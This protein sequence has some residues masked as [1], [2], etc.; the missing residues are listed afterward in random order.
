[1]QRAINSNIN[2]NFPLSKTFHIVAETLEEKEAKLLEKVK[3]D[4]ISFLQSYQ[5]Y[6]KW[7]WKKIKRSIRDG[8][9]EY[10]KRLLLVIKECKELKLEGKKLVNRIK[11]WLELREDWFRFQ[12][13][14][15]SSNK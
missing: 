15:I 4:W 1:M 5:K 3:Q 13:S 14:K 7:P 8:G 9:K 2:Q 6:S 10:L 11:K 12:Q